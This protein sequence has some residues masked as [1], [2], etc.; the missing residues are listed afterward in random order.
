MRPSRFVAHDQVAMS[1]LMLGFT[2]HRLLQFYLKVN[3]ML[4][5]QTQVCYTECV[6]YAA[7]FCIL[8]LKV[9]TPTRRGQEAGKEGAL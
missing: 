9:Q 4:Y 8:L 2:P 7:F 1:R 3:K 5:F 6:E